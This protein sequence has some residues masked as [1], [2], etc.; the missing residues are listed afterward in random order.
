M[1]MV[2]DNYRTFINGLVSLVRDGKIGIERIDD[3]NRRILN[4][5]FEM[6]L[7]EAPFTHRT[8]AGMVGSPAHREVARQCVRESLV[9]L[10]NKNMILPLAEG[11]GHLHVAGRSAD[12]LG[13]QCGGW[14][15][16]WQGG[17][18]DITIGTTILEAIRAVA[19]GEVSY[20]EAGYSPDADGAEAAV[21]VIGEAPYAEGSGDRSSLGLSQADIQA[22]KSLY[23]RGFKVVTI[24]VS[25]RPLILEEVWHYLMR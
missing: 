5:K 24:L 17:S 23:D 25:G 14:S 3:A 22:V 4:Q 2:P 8:M 10:K 1:V 19:G 9:V 12:N 20:T 11:T 21:V 18:G 16:S 7:F 13:Y 6:G 15:I